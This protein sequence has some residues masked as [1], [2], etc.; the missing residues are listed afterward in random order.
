MGSA[1]SLRSSTTSRSS[2]MVLTNEITATVRTATVAR[3]TIVTIT[4]AKST[5]LT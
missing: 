5:A 1:E 2:R 4:A 3:Q